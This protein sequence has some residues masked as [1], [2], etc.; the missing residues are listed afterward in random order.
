M[1]AKRSNVALGVGFAAAICALGCSSD[2]NERDPRAGLRAEAGENLPG[3]DTTNTLLFG[4]KAFTLIA[5]NATEEH[6][7]LF[8]AGNSFF[9]SSW[10]Q[11]PSSTSGRDGLGPLFNAR[12]CSTCHF[13]DGRGRPPLTDDEEFSSM[14]LRIGTGS[15]SADGDPEGDPTY[16]GQLQPFAIND[17]PAEG[18]PKHT[19]SKT[20]GTF[21]EGEAYELLAPTYWIE[22]EAYGPMSASLVISPRVAPQ[23]IGLGLLGAISE[24]ELMARSDPDDADGDGISGRPN[25]VR[26]VVT[27]EFTMGRFGWKA[28][29]PFVRQQAAGAFQG[30]IGITS[31][32]FPNQDCS[33]VEV[34]CGDA[35]NGGEPEASDSV[36]D[37]VDVY[38]QLLAPPARP[39]YAEQ[40][41]LEGKALFSEVGCDSCH[42]PR[43]VTGD[44]ELE[45]L[46]GQT[47]WPYT[48]LLLHDMGETL[49][50]ARPSFAAEGSEWRTPPLWG[51][52]RI[53]EVNGHNRLLHD[54]RARGVTEAILAHAGEGTAARGA[55]TS[56]SANERGML[57]SF[58]ESL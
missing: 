26:D 24:D 5:E 1:T 10:V 44:S 48:D 13:E 4:I 27:G 22:G 57:V 41:I 32:L 8:F 3:G 2:G 45:E 11:A 7:S 47:I 55:F 17:V 50:D 16:G 42:T 36:L 43:Y 40:E 49:S 28:E 58:V 18:T 33:D 37:A 51:I 34:A 56:L 54:G 15:L 25:L 20:R 35:A 52:G 21:A 30:D 19:C 46:T 23:M 38:S 53:P 12:S 31:S 9:N 29:Q 6:K 39:H 14:L